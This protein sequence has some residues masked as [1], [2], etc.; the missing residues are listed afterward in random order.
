[1]KILTK[2]GKIREKNEILMKKVKKWS[3]FDKK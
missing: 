3:F 1:M 2:N